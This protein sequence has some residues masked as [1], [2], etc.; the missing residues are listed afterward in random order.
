MLLHEKYR[1]KLLSDVVAQSDAVRLVSR[2]DPGGRAFYITGQ[3]GTGKTTIARIL[4]LN[5]AHPA[6]ITELVAR[7][8]SPVM[9]RDWLFTVS[10]SRPLFGACYVLIVNESHGLS[11]ACVEVFLDLIEALPDWAIV[12]FTTTNDGTN[13]FEDT[14][15][16]ASPF[17]SRCM[18]VRLKSRDITG[19]MAERC[20]FIAEQEHLD[21]KP[22]EDYIKLLREHRNNMRSALM[23]IESG[24]ML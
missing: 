8:V 11:K 12:I 13:L 1:P 10:A 24:R 5:S 21:G 19:P 22:I 6:A 2:L 20:K 4:A 18:R 16:D 3:S 14:A 7:Q 17:I 15:F 9:L 23:D